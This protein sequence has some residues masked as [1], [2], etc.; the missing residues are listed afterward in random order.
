MGLR[1]KLETILFLRLLCFCYI[2]ILAIFGLAFLSIGLPILF[3]ATFYLLTVLASLFVF[4]DLLATTNLKNSVD[5]IVK[6]LDEF[7]IKQKEEKK[8]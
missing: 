8:C 6:E 2:F 5:A 4:G 1:K 7:I 3:Q